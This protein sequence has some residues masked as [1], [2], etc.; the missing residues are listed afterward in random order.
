M[1]GCLFD[2]SGSRKYLIASERLAIL[3]TALD[4]GGPS[5]ALCLVL[6][7]T[8]A[9][10]SE[11]L[12]LTRRRIDCPNRAII[13]ETL[14]RRR[15]G[16]FR[17]VPVPEKL[18]RYIE[19]VMK[20]QALTEDDQIWTWGRTTAWKEVKAIMRKAGIIEPLCMPK[21]LRHGFGACAGQQAVPLNIIQRWLG[22]AR[23]ETTAIYVDVLGDDERRLAQHAWNSLE[24]EL[25]TGA[26]YP[27]HRPPEAFRYRV[28]APQPP[29]DRPSRHRN[30]IG[31]A[32][33]SDLPVRS[34]VASGAPVFL[35]STANF[36]KLNATEW[37]SRA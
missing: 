14:K 21:A 17:A 31:P 11:A 27:P 35:A 32:T 10:I 29:S 1:S 2:T 9:R 5:G 33:Y 25:G 36:E 8:G 13:I 6:L 20:M 28:A 18:L 24:S 37:R 15:R 12:N 4:E 30:S 34:F 7:F 22:H 16:V 19:E 3:S 26:T 23:I